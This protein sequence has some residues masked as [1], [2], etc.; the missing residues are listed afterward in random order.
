[1]FRYVCLCLFS[2]LLVASAEAGE[3]RHTERP[4]PDRYIVTLKAD[5]PATEVG[6]V[7]RALATAYGADVFVILSHGIKA[8]GAVMSE[9]DA[10]R[11]ANHPVVEAVEQDGYAEYSYTEITLPGDDSLW[12]LDRIDQHDL[13]GTN[14]KYAYTA[15][16]QGVRAYVIDSGIQASHREFL[17]GNP[18]ST[19]LADTSANGTRV[20][21]GLNIDASDNFPANNPCGGWTTSDKSTHGTAVASVLGGTYSGVAKRV[22]LV[23]VKVSRC[24]TDPSNIAVAWGLDQVLADMAGAYRPAPYQNVPRTEPAL[25]N[26]SLFISNTSCDGVP[27][28]GAVENNIQNVIGADIPVIVSANNRHE[29]ACGDRE[30]AS[31]AR[32]GHGNYTSGTMTGTVATTAGNLTLTGT[33]THFRTELGL[34]DLITVAGMSGE[35]RIQSIAS[36]TL[37]YLSLASPVSVSGKAATIVSPWRRAPYRTITVGGSMRLPSSGNVDVAW[38]CVTRG[39]TVLPGNPGTN[40]G[41][42]VDIYAPSW[43]VQVARASGVCDYR[44]AEWR[45][46]TSYAAPAVAGA[47]ARLLEMSPGDTPQQIW[48]KLETAATH[49]LSTDPLTGAPVDFDDEP[50][51]FNNK[52][53]YISPYE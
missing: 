17:T 37:A 19:C 27:C 48:N 16:G 39:C 15:T 13:I 53:L 40:Y 29:N 9:K 26:M 49:V 25:V 36:E 14:K 4:I 7:A 8:F 11:L 35:H 44:S 1:M 12:L 52:L 28:Q 34:G 21:V 18:A 6:H 31:P 10:H 23:P 30:T 50:W 2:Y 51:S 32:L 5:T 20:E 47:V 46:G 38:D 43:M 22:T 33:G 45:S 42:C 41:R 3:F 24:D